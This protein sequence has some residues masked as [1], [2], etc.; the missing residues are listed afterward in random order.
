MYAR[1]FTSAPVPHLSRCYAQT[2]PAMCICL[3]SCG[4]F[5][6]FQALS[7][8]LFLGVWF[9][10]NP[11][12]TWSE[13]WQDPDPVPFIGA[14]W[15]G[16]VSYTF[17]QIGKCVTSVRDCCLFFCGDGGGRE[18]KF[19]RMPSSASNSRLPPSEA[20]AEA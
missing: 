20:E 5:L 16:L 11:D 13:F 12:L 15:L 14:L 10:I 8:T 4:T 9:A 7:L 19:S 6:A 18:A 1:K 3:P 2:A 17:F